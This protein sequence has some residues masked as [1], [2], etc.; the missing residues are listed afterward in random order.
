MSFPTCR[1]ELQ[2]PEWIATQRKP[3]QG[4]AAGTKIL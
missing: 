3:N 1:V 4:F 2:N